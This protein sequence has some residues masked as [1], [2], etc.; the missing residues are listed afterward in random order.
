MLCLWES[1]QIFAAAVA[2]KEFE[3]YHI[4]IKFTSLDNNLKEKINELHDF[5]QIGI[6]H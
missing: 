6:F 2:I 1:E 4:F 5:N 3:S